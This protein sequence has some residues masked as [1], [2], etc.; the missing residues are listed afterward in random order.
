MSGHTSKFRLL[1]ETIVV[2][3]S[4]IIFRC[5]NFTPHELRDNKFT[6]WNYPILNFRLFHADL[7]KRYLSGSTKSAT[8]LDSG[9]YVFVLSMWF[10]E[11]VNISIGVS[12]KPGSRGSGVDFPKPAKG[13]KRIASTRP[14]S[15]QHESHNSGPRCGVISFTCRRTQVD[16]NFRNG[17]AEGF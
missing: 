3:K 14:R 6:D 13:V 15:Y 7:D 17:Y 12:F 8:D 9:T 4:E 16:L 10:C 5:R 2:Y 11:C 1:V